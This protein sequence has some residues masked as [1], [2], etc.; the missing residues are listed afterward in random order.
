MMQTEWRR[1]SLLIARELRAHAEA[2]GMTP[3]QLA[4]AWVLNNRLVTSVIC[5]PRTEAQLSDYLGALE[6]RFSSESEALVGSLVAAGHPSTPGYAD[7]MEPV[8]G[9]V[10][11]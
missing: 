8:E 10:P 6:V 1:E 3:S 11:R 7:P 4:V 2:R 9:R 5:G